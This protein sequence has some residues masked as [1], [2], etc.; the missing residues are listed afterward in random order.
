[1]VFMV[2]KL[3][4]K[5][6]KHTK[7]IQEDYSLIGTLGGEIDTEL[8]FGTLEAARDSIID[9][10]VVWNQEELEMLREEVKKT[11]LSLRT[12]KLQIAQS[13]RDKKTD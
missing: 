2:K 8:G 11:K 13:K 1:M 9:R 12:H 6:K 5:T 10:N 4:T 7:I 3:F